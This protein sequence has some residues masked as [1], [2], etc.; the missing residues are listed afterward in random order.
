MHIYR[1]H[2]YIYIRWCIYT[3]IYVYIYIYNYMLIS[4]CVNVAYIHTHVFASYIFF[5]EYLSV[6]VLFAERR[7]KRRSRRSYRPIERAEVRGRGPS[8]AARGCSTSFPPN[9]RCANRFIY[10]DMYERH[11]QHERAAYDHIILIRML[12]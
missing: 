4:V 5:A 11:I 2:I 9:Q 12:L 3:C 6:C 10:G 8:R 7:R 1:A